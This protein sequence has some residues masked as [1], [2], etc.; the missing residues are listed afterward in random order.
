[1]SKGGVGG[2]EGNRECHTRAQLPEPMSH[3]TVI[4]TVKPRVT[5]PGRTSR[6]CRSSRG[7]RHVVSPL[8]Q[9]GR[10]G[11]VWTRNTEIHRCL[12]YAGIELHHCGGRL[13]SSPRSVYQGPVSGA[14]FHSVAAHDDATV[15]EPDFEPV[16]IT[17]LVKT[18]IV[19]FGS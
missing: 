2:C 3:N 7:S 17:P 1:M 8:G 18:S 14:P 16:V 5:S 10:T 13:P 19:V 6:Q 15:K 11:R 4:R 9:S 12:T